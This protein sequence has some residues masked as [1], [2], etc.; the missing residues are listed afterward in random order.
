MLNALIRTA[1][2]K[3]ENRNTEAEATRRAQH[4]WRVTEVETNI[5]YMGDNVGDK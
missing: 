1:P 5:Y 4:R 2:S 3:E